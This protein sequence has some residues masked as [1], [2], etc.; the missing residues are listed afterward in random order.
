M[1]A[2]PL[3]VAWIALA[4]FF[5]G[6]SRRKKQKETIMKYQNFFGI[7]LTV[8][9][10][11]LSLTGCTPTFDGSSAKNA[12]SYKLDVKVM[13]C[14]DSHSFELNQGDTLEILFE[15]EKGSLVMKITA[16][17]GTVLYQGD[18]TVKQ[19]IVEAPMHGVYPIVVTGKNAKGSIHIDV[20]RDTEAVEPD[21]VVLTEDDLIMAD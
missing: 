2:L 9:I 15:T 14:T 6:C 5:V 13:N 16:P 4:V 11:L 7:A 17:D 3:L 21:A 19:F 20:E 8:C 10:L 18:G 12:D 1:A